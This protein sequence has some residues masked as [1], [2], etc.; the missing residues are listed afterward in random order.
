MNAWAPVPLRLA[1]GTVF[2]LK[3]WWVLFGELAVRTQSFAHAGVPWPLLIALLFGALEFFGGALLFLGLYVRLVAVLLLAVELVAIGPVLL[4][5]GFIAGWALNLL[6]IG[7]IASLL[8][9]GP[10]RLSLTGK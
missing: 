8:L 1:V 10:G 4:Q 5:R 3:G 9:S 6:L 2:A 7:G